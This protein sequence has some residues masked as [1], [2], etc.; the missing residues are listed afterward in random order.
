MQYRYTSSSD[1][2]LT[3]N[4]P[5]LRIEES[6]RDGGGHG[7]RESDG[8]CVAVPCITDINDVI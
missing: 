4:S 5:D 3:Y 2:S 1:S 6:D 7:D 8:E